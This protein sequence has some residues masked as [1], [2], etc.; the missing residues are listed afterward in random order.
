[1]ST[2]TNI[3]KNAI[4]NHPKLVTFSIGL[5]ITF[6]VTLATGL[7]SPEQAFA[8]GSGNCTNCRNLN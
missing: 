7:I 1:M 4:A 8:G 5:A 6:G 3:I 2:I